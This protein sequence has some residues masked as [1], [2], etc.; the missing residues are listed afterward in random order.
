MFPV[1]C[2][3]DRRLILN[4]LDAGRGSGVGLEAGSKAVSTPT[5]LY[6]LLCLLTFRMAS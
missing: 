6:L 5:S 3:H 1:K 2:N 4:M